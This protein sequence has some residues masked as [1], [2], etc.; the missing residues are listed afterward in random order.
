MGENFLKAGSATKDKL[1]LWAYSAAVEVANDPNTVSDTLGALQNAMKQAL[2]MAN[3]L[4][5]L[6]WRI[7]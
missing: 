4:C 7:K 2:F 6:S 3:Y 1:L 5:L